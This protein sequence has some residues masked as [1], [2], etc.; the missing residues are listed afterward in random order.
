MSPT[1]ANLAFEA[2]NVLL[3]AAGLGYLL[4]RPIRAALDAERARRAEE[5]ADVAARREEADALARRAREAEATARREAE[6]RRAEAEAAG[7]AQAAALVEEALAER[8]RQRARLAAELAALREEQAAALASAVGELAARSVRSLL[9]AVG[10]PD[11]DLALV[12]AACAE[13]AALP[14]GA[15]A[16]AAVECARP[17]SEEALELL[18]SALGAPP[19]PKRVPELGAGVRITTAAGQV[20]ATASALARQAAR[21]VSE[22]PAPRGEEPADAAGHAEGGAPA[23]EPGAEAV[24]A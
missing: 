11:L 19:D 24:R 20:D 10:G 23:A 3:L 5:Q 13:L 6:A 1:L 2:V 15:R 17:L 12:R 9:A 22:P 14:P 16:A 8:E 21:A 4:F 7:R 18:A